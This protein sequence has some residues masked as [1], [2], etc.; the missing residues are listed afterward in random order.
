[1]SLADDLRAR[2]RAFAP[3]ALELAAFQRTEPWRRLQ[4]LI[5]RWRD[6]AEVGLVDLHWPPRPLDA[7]VEAAERVVHKLPVDR[8]DTLL[9]WLVALGTSPA[10]AG[11]RLSGRLQRLLPTRPGLLMA[12]V[13][14]VLMGEPVAPGAELPPWLA[15]AVKAALGDPANTQHPGLAFLKNLYPRVNAE[16]LAWQAVQRNLP[17]QDL[18]RSLFTLALPGNWRAAAEEGIPSLAERA[19]SPIDVHRL[20]VRLFKPLMARSPGDG[21]RIFSSVDGADP[22]DRIDNPE[23]AE[24]RLWLSRQT[25]HRERLSVGAREVLARWRGVAGYRDFRDILEAWSNDP[26]HEEW[27]ANQ[28]KQRST[29]WGH[30]QSRIRGARLCLSSEVKRSMESENIEYNAD[31]RHPFALL[32]FDQ[33]AIRVPFA[34]SDE[35]LAMRGEG[36][37]HLLDLT[38][39]ELRDAIHR[40]EHE[41][42]VRIVIEGEHDIDYAWVQDGFYLWQVATTYR[43]VSEG[44]E[45]DAGVNRFADLPG[46]YERGKGLPLP[47]KEKIL[48]L[49]TRKGSKVEDSHPVVAR[50]LR[51]KRISPAEVAAARAEHRSKW[52]HR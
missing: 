24:V 25:S 11:G 15:N 9:E 51:L 8:P 38:F 27:E 30:Y 17:L 43:L 42:G 36:L 12:V 31:V 18:P 49:L 29:F 32:V 41:G 33:L 47:D 16:V 23:W 5:A 22:K 1:V 39:A 20:I 2:A 35:M 21:W 40:I 37:V 45:P 3:A 46:A 44:L 26:R 14:N 50:A 4:A 34:G 28:L 52:A 48:S 13:L 19:L 10:A 6:D 7:L